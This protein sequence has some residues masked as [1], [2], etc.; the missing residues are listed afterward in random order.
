MKTRL[1]KTVKLL[2]EVNNI[3]L[4]RKVQRPFASSGGVRNSAEWSNQWDVSLW[5]YAIFTTAYII[6]R[7]FYCRGSLFMDDGQIYHA[8]HE[9]LLTLQH[10]PRFTGPAYWGITRWYISSDRGRSEEEPSAEITGL[11]RAL[12]LQ[13]RKS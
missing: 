3:F 5:C 12:V 8:P 2:A 1:I 9:H 7:C 13:F 11:R 4:G 10:S 6:Q